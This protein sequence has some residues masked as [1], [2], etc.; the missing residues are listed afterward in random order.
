MPRVSDLFRAERGAVVA[1]AGC[2]KTHLIVEALG[3]EAD[4]PTLVLTHTTAGVAAL[5]RRL[6]EHNVSSKNYRLTTIDAWAINLISMFPDNAGYRIDRTQAPDYTA[7][8]NAADHLLSR[9]ALTPILQATYGRIF[10]DEYQDCSRLQ[11]RIISRLA[12]IVPTIIFGDPMQAIFGFGGDPLPSW[13]DDVLTTFPLLGELTIPYRWN[14]KEAPDLGNWLLQV[15]AALLNGQ[16]IDLR[17]CPERVFWKQITGNPQQDLQHQISAQYDIERAHP[18][19]SLLIIGDS[20][21]VA[22][23]HNYASHSRGVSVVERVDYPDVVSSANRMNEQRGEQLFLS[24]IE[25][26]KLVTVN[27]YSDRLLQRINSITNGRNRSPATPE[28]IAAIKLRNDGG[29]SEAAD[30]MKKIVRAPDRRLYRHN[31]YAVM[32]KALEAGATNV[33]LPLDEHVANIREQHRHAGRSILKKSVGSTLL[34]KGLEADHVLILDA[35]IPDGRR[36]MNANH[37]Y[38]ALSRGA[39]SITIFSRN[40][41]L[42]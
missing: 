5:K 4:K 24:T 6:S 14:N 37:L 42:P 31:A 28:E 39:K 19:D 20:I 25:F 8:K 41:I 22:S 21:Q 13:N 26:L 12:D 33:E 7:F 29:Y 17:T 23:R 32:L 36:R 9:N 3:S 18:D 16:A 30:F 27:L 15:R 40:P 2:G 11:H 38:V 10:V 1:P 35:D 34:L